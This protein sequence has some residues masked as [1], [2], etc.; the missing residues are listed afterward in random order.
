MQRELPP[1]GTRRRGF[2]L[3]E[4]LV[5]I[6]VIGVLIAMLLPAVQAAREAAR[7]MQCANNLKQIGLGLLNY[8]T[9]HK[10]LPPSHGR[11]PD[12]SILAFILP[13]MEQRA[14][15]DLYHFEHSWDEPANAAAVGMDVASFI[16]PSA[17]GGRKAI[18]D[19]AVCLSIAPQAYQPLV[20]SGAITDRSDWNS[21]IQDEPNPT[22]LR[23][24]RDGLSH[25]FMFFEDGGRPERHRLGKLL[26]GKAG[27]WRWADNSSYFCLHRVCRGS[28]MINCENNNEIYSFH[29]GGCNFLY[30]DGSVHFH[31]DE[32]E[33][34][35]FVSLFT[36]AAGDIVPY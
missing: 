16:C 22:R 9:S 6:A 3:V 11:D 26:P 35:V 17:P 31:P 15:A 27:G 10:V 23:D 1:R 34:E 29:L 21:I 28:Q 5:V 4:L 19:Y 14:V 32:I 13:L 2:S 25:S 7:R 18:S 12:H 20:R 30:G 8:E 24:V 33:P 36:M